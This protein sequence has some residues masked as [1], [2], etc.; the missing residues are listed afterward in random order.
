MRYYP[1]VRTPEFTPR[2]QFV[3]EARSNPALAVLEGLHALKHAMRFGAPI[4]EAYTDSADDLAA[5]VDDLAPDLSA[6]IRDIVTPVDED[7]FSEFAAGPLPSR[8]IAVAERKRWTVGDALGGDSPTV[9]LENPSYPGNVGAVI[10]VAA[11]AGASGV[12]V[13]G[14]LDPWTPAAIRGA[15]GLHYAV[16]VASA[17]LDEV[18]RARLVAVDPDGVPFDPRSI[19]HDAVLAFGT[20]RHGLSAI[21][22]DRAAARVALPMRPGVSSLNLATSVAAILYL[23]RAA[24]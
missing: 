9:F 13:S 18:P 1:R 7:L 17:G 16:P 21:L 8:V 4:V 22:L 6:R 10:R 12:L 5:L 19:P 15:A 3:R 24:R 14:A 23:W 20:E 2:A 11:A